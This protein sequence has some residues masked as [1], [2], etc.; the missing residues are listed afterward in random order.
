MDF[1]TK[2]TIDGTKMWHH[3]NIPTTPFVWVSFLSYKTNVL[4]VTSYYILISGITW[5]CGEEDDEIK[6][7]AHKLGLRE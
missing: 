5:G 7:M 6:G 1:A 3:V 2:G 4:F